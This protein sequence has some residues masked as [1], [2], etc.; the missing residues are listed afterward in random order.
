MNWDVDM[1]LSRKSDLSMEG[2]SRVKGA[3]FVKVASGS[4]VAIRKLV[5]DWRLLSNYTPIEE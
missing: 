5:I 1:D 3:Y 2:F 4:F